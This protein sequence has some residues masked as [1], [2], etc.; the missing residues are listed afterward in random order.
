M[1]LAILATIQ[2]LSYQHLPPSTSPSIVVLSIIKLQHCSVPFEVSEFL[3]LENIIE[4]L[5]DVV[6]QCFLMLEFRLSL[7]IESV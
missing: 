1:P 3:H 7:N 2:G 6:N 4:Y 5:H